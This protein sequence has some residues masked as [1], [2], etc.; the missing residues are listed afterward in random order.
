MSPLPHLY[1]QL[2]L[3]TV[4]CP[5]HILAIIA[6]TRVLHGPPPSPNGDILQL[7]VT[8]NDSSVWY[9]IMTHKH[10]SS[11]FASIIRFP[12]FLCSKCPCFHSLRHALPSLPLISTW[13]QFPRILKS[14]LLTFLIPRCSA[15]F[16]AP[17][18]QAFHCRPL[19]LIIH[20]PSFFLLSERPSRSCHTF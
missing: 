9:A 8:S 17:L 12:C 3:L 6:I 15:S 4:T 7:K 10:S 18:F 11:I 20:I 19:L 16:Y 13:L 5:L 14:S 2:N 1:R